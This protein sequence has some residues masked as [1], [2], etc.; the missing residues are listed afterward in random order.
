MNQEKMGKLI[1]ELRKEKNMTQNELADKLNVNGKTVSRWENGNQSPDISLLE[2]IAKEFGIS[3]EELL[4]GERNDK[5]DNN[6]AEFKEKVFEIKKKLEYE[7]KH[8]PKKKLTF[9]NAK[10]PALSSWFESSVDEANA[11]IAQLNTDI[12]NVIIE[13]KLNYIHFNNQGK[14]SVIF[15]KII[16]ETGSIIS[17]L[18]TDTVEGKEFVKNLK[19][20]QVYR[21]KGNVRFDEELFE[22]YVLFLCGIDGISLN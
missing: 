2:P 13:G 4:K 5:I 3:I 21:F 20:N 14:N 16:D 18:C 8:S 22:E 11:K 12:S 10:L 15:L 9:E 1:S 7:K 19:K 6:S 17:L